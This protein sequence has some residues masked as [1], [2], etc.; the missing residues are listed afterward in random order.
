MA[1]KFVIFPDEDQPKRLR[2]SFQSANGTYVFGSH[3][4]FADEYN[5]R[6]SIE[7]VKESSDADVE[8]IE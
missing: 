7:L 2:W 8:V 6:Q 4:S 5:A 1:A 3:N